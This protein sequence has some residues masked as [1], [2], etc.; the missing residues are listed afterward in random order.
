MKPEI[1]PIENSELESQ[2]LTLENDHELPAEVEGSA[3]FQDTEQGA[4]TM[5]KIQAVKESIINAPVS[6]ETAFGTL[7]PEGRLFTPTKAEDSIQ[8]SKWPSWLRKAFVFTGI[9]ATAVL[10]PKDA[11]GTEKGGGI[12]DKAGSKTEIAAFM[13]NETIRPITVQEQVA[14]NAYVDFLNGKKLKGDERLNHAEFSEELVDEFNKNASVPLELSSIKSIQHAINQIKNE[15][16]QKVKEGKA[17]VVDTK[18]NTLS[19][20]SLMKNTSPEDGIPGSKTTSYKF[21]TY[22]NINQQV[23]GVTLHAGKT[24]QDLQFSTSKTDTIKEGLIRPSD[25]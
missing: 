5:E 17:T 24:G 22:T 21:P 8:K 3:M 15:E 14:W 1:P 11:H 25:K 12:K 6:A 19:V 16:I 4:E 20:D 9:T 13:K 2:T 23:D 18:G 10:A 7:S